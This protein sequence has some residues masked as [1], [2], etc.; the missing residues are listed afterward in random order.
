MPLAIAGAV[1]VVGAPLGHRVGVLPL[2][3]A[4]LALLIG[5]LLSLVVLP[6][7]VTRLVRGLDAPGSRRPVMGAAAISA[8]T[9]LWPLLMVLSAL[10][11]PAIHDIHRSRRPPTVRRRGAVARRCGELA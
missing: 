4:F 6:V 11:L 1:A 9:G 10:G 8:V 7:A 5:V 2:A 3:I